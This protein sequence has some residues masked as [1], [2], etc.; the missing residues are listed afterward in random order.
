[1]DWVGSGHET[2]YSV[3]LST[4]LDVSQA[5]Q[6]DYHPSGRGV[7]DGLAFDRLATIALEL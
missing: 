7:R 1:M 2:S 5:R 6:I 4:A 3:P